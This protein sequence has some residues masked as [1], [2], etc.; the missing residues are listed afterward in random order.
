M[1]LWYRTNTRMIINNTKI[2]NTTKWR[3]LSILLDSDQVVSNKTEIKKK[4]YKK[5][6]KLPIYIKMYRSH[7]KY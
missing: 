3:K 4:Q 6:Y 1:K 5:T 2:N 7:K